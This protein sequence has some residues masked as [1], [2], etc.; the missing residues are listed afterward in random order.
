MGCFPSAHFTLAL[1]PAFFG[2]QARGSADCR[3][4]VGAGGTLL[5]VPRFLG[6]APRYDR[7]GRNDDCTEKHQY[8]CARKIRKRSAQAEKEGASVDPTDP[9]AN[10]KTPD[11]GM[12]RIEHV[13]QAPSGAFDD[14]GD[15]PARERSRERR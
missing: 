12:R 4:G 2:L 8:H 11:L 3:A 1:V 14:V 5:G 13:D 15:K 6:D 10:D 7:K 9:A